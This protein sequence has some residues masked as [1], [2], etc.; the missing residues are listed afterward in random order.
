MPPA[1]SYEEYMFQSLITG[2]RSAGIAGRLQRK[3][4]EYSQDPRP[5][6]DTG[7]GTGAKR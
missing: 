7:V 4:D 1:E 5:R 6:R 2:Q 3:L